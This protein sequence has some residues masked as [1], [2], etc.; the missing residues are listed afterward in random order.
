MTSDAM[1]LWAV[2]FFILSI[3]GIL[4]GKAMTI[5]F[6]EGVVRIEDKILRLL[7]IDAIS[8]MNWKEYL[9]AII[10]FNLFGFIFLQVILMFQDWFPLNP[11]G[12]NGL[13]FWMAFNITSSFITNT[14]WQN[15]AGESTLSYFSQMM[16]LTV[17][18]YLSAATGVAVLIAF[19]RSLVKKEV[20]KI[21]NFWSDITHFT[22]RILLPLSFI[23]ALFLIY[24]GVPQTFN[25][26]VGIKTLEGK[27]LK[28]PVGPVASQIAI[29][30]NG[31]NGG[32]FYNA[33]AAHPYE[34]PTPL[35]NFVQLVSILLIPVSCAFMLIFMLPR[36]KDGLPILGVMT[37]M[38]L[39]GVVLSYFAQK[40]GNPMVQMAFL[41]GTETRFSLAECSLWSVATTAV[42]N[43]SV[44]CMHSSLSPLA[45]MIALF[46]M[47][48]GEVIFGGAGCG[49][50]GML[51]Y[52]LMTVFLAGLMVGRTPEYL[53]KKIESKEIICASFAFLAPG[54][55]NLI[56]SAWALN[57]RLGLSSLS[58]WSIPSILDKKSYPLYPSVIT[59]PLNP[60][61][62]SFA[63]LPDLVASN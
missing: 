20:S 49:L 4:I 39:I 33:N 47:M 32:G 19:I 38:L 12:K 22:L 60:F 25:S 43:G 27:E 63:T 17:Q 1:I 15:Y 28:V 45:Q 11:E 16:G 34:N 42:S 50:Y 2:Y 62:I 44:N 23:L 51:L 57:Y 5:L 21:G 18:N 55:L 58:Q 13:P 53:G 3:L 26:S 52:V 59:T 37:V 29:K 54:L 14:N 35:A 40:Q 56:F 46:N 61:S 10:V 41:E 6:K 30:M 7:K 8:S 36:K 24:Q 31:T 48:T 9:F